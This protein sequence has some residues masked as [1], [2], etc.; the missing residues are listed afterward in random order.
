MLIPQPGDSEPESIELQYQ[1]TD[2]LDTNWNYVS[3][4]HGLYRR[5]ASPDSRHLGQKMYLLDGG[6]DWES[7]ADVKQRFFTTGSAGGDIV[8]FGQGL[9]QQ[10]RVNSA[11]D[12]YAQG[13]ARSVTGLNITLREQCN[14]PRLSRIVDGADVLWLGG[15][16]QSFYTSR[17]AGTLMAASLVRA[18]ASPVAIG[19]T[20]A[21]LA[22]L[23]QFAC[24]D[25]PWDSVRGSFAPQ[26]PFDTRV[27]V[28]PQGSPGLPF[29]S[30]STGLN[31]PLSGFLFDTHFSSRDRMGRLITFAAR[32]RT[33]GIGV[34]EETSLLVEPAG[35]N[36]WRWSVY[37]E[38]SVYLVGQM[39]SRGLRALNAWFLQ[40]SRLTTGELSVIRL[41]AGRTAGGLLRSNVFTLA[42]DDRIKVITGTVFTLNNGGSLYG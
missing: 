7:M 17:W 39:P 29:A 6:S 9:E 31:S 1:V 11:F 19:G 14:D 25:L 26:R 27:N 13:T 42:A 38:D 3:I 5:G 21:G 35:R 8:L 37:G 12:D 2:G 30:L 10:D 32:S 28:L 34:D 4:S 36:D 20:S 18:A 15:G 22:V 16:A 40:D 23:G 24:V 33:I 41:D